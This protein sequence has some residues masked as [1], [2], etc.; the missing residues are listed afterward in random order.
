MKEVV[1]K[2]IE[3]LCTEFKNDPSFRFVFSKIKDSETKHLAKK[4][5]AF[6]I[7]QANGFLYRLDNDEAHFDKELDSKFGDFKDRNGCYYD[8]KVGTTKYCGSIG[9]D[10]LNHF[11][12]TQTDKHWYICVN[13][14]FSKCYIINARVLKE[15]L[16]NKQFNNSEEIIE[17]RYLGEL[18]Y[19]KLHSELK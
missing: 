18:D 12:D 7:L 16:D 19:K 14:T 9:L 13:P 10:S 3:K 6:L 17:K 4:Q 5:E 1:N 11:G 15:E 2:D 8:L